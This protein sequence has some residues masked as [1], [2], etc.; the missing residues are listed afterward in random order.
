VSAAFFLLRA[1]P[2]DA[3][4]KQSTALSDVCGYGTPALKAQLRPADEQFGQY[5]ILEFFAGP[6]ATIGYCSRWV[7]DDVQ[8]E[9]PNLCVEIRVLSEPIFTMRGQVI[10]DKTN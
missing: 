4:I 5:A 8:V 10:L 9:D 3:R 1:N 6:S 2:T 7:Q